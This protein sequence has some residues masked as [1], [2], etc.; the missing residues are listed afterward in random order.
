MPTPIPVE[1]PLTENQ[2]SRLWRGVV[3]PLLLFCMAVAILVAAVYLTAARN[4]RH[5]DHKSAPVSEGR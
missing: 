4:E 3:A 5:L 2:K 1:K